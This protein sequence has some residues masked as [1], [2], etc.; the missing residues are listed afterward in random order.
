MWRKTQQS[1]TLFHCNLPW[2]LH[3][4]NSWW[5]RHWCFLYLGKNTNKES[6]YI[7]WI[8]NRPSRLL[9]R[10]LSFSLYVSLEL[11]VLITF[12]SVLFFRSLSRGNCANSQTKVS[13]DIYCFHL[14]RRKVWKELRHHIQ[15]DR[16]RNHLLVFVLC[17]SSSFCK[18]FVPISSVDSKASCALSVFFS[19]KR[20]RATLRLKRKRRRYFRSKRGKKRHDNNRTTMSD[21]HKVTFA[22]HDPNIYKRV[23]YSN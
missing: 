22:L 16:L 19:L 10:S 14:V 7:P 13:V 4:I 8:H 3:S 5:W 23:E 15:F 11:S 17:L 9:S 1:D 2:G 6:I 20:R 18:F 21:Y 12:S